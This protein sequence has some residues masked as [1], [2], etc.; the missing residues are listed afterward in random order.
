MY[1]RQHKMS[2]NDGS[3]NAGCPAAAYANSATVPSPLPP[4]PWVTSDPRLVNSMRAEMARLRLSSEDLGALIGGRSGE[5]VDGVLNGRIRP[6]LDDLHGFNDHLDSPMDL[7]AW[8]FL[9]EMW[10]KS[11]ERVRLI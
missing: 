3:D 7:L 9:G 10:Y 11:G 1:A 6:T 8:V 2:N 5:Y 4:C